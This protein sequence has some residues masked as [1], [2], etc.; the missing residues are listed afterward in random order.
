MI[1][2]AGSH[3][4]APGVL[5]LLFLFSC[6]LFFGQAV[7]AIMF[8]LDDLLLLT[9]LKPSGFWARLHANHNLALLDTV[10]DVLA[11][12]LLDPWLLKGSLLHR[13]AEDVQVP[14][15]FCRLV[16]LLTNPP[17]L[18]YCFYLWP[19]DRNSDSR[20]LSST[21]SFRCCPH[22]TTIANRARIIQTHS[23]NIRNVQH[24]P[25]HTLWISNRNNSRH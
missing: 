15:L 25:S 16:Y 13:Y 24:A 19:N 4:S 11:P 22:L 14:G 23:T 8:M 10:F 18:P 7:G 5:L 17:A 20:A 6:I 12:Y 1:P 21:L 9:A 2:A 3:H